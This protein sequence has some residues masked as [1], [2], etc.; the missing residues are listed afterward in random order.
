MS[1]SD[2]EIKEKLQKLV[3]DSIKADEELRAKFQIGDKFRFVRDRL[4]ALAARI[5]EELDALNMEIESKTDKIAEDEM[6][7][8]VYIFNAQGLVLQ[9]WQKMLNPAVFYEYSVNRPV[10]RE[11]AHVESFV[12]SRTTKAQHGFLTVIVK[13]TDILPVV[14]GV[15][16]LLDPIGNPL[17]KIRE[18]SLKAERMYSFV[19]QENEYVVDK[20]GQIVKKD[21]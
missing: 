18:G 15:D 21:L 20:T 4:T 19:H 6:L 13:K 16:A 5:Q 7:V 10:Y 8:Y 2:K 3:Q 11:K 17:I 14:A 9:T 1:N 12:R